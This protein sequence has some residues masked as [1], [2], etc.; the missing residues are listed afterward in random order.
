MGEMIW[1]PFYEID[2]P[3]KALFE[4]ALAS[5]HLE[6]HYAVAVDITSC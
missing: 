3:S 4:R 5:D 1:H 6:E 2:F